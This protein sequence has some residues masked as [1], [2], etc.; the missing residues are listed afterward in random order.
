MHR[1]ARLT[2]ATLALLFCLWAAA[3]CAAQTTGS[4]SIVSDAAYASLMRALNPHLRENQS[5]AYASA[6]VINSRRM[7]VDPALVMAVVTVESHWDVNAVSPDGAEGL[8][9]LIPQTAHSLGVN[10]W[11]GT[12]NIRGITIYLH[13]LLGLFSEARQ[14]IREALAGYNA[15]PYAVK[16]FGG[17]PSGEPQRYVEKV[18]DT[19]HAVRAR[20]AY[21]Y[22]PSPVARLALDPV[23]SVERAQDA[24]WGAH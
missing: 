8:G 20:L 15:G 21:T 16:D 1:A 9:Q 17:V 3:P 6:L 14:P 12:S 19:L 24:Y 2:R 18:L 13:R 5:R 22:V 4:S 10:P 7:H 23:R 11:S